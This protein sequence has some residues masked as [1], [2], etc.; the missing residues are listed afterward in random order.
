M[1]L[2]ASLVGK[3]TMTSAVSGMSGSGASVSASL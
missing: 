2:A 3:R 1:W